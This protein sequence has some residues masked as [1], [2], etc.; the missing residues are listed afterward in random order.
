[1]NLSFP[2]ILLAIAVVLF[3]ASCAAGRKPVRQEMASRSGGNVQPSS[4]LF[5]GNSYSFEIPKKLRRIAARHGKDVR[6]AQVTHSGWSLEQHVRNEETLRKIREGN[7]DV[8]VIQEQSRIP[9]QAI[10]RIHAM[11]PHVRELA[12]EARAVG[13]VPVLYQTWGRRN[14]DEWYPGNDDF[15]AMNHRLREG[16]RLAAQ[17][18]G[19]LTVVPVGDAWESEV[20]AGRGAR[21]FMPDGSHATADGDDLTAKVFYETLFLQGSR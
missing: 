15:H 6:V 9:S 19:G 10:K 2:Q 7:W 13:A 8:V 5:I 4:V 1:L 21:L 12:D 16:Y 17:A 3:L 20:S 14:G 11:F 18:A